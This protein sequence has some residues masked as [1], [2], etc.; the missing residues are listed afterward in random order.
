MANNSIRVLTED[1]VKQLSAYIEHCAQEVRRTRGEDNNFR[2][3][4]PD[5]I[6]PSIITIR[7]RL[8]SEV[9]EYMYFS[10]LIRDFSQVLQRGTVT[11]NEI[12]WYHL[13]TPIGFFIPGH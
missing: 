12:R 3:A 10:N 13:D 6:T 2:I 7:E 9:G 8:E 1:E 5:F 4:R 11:D